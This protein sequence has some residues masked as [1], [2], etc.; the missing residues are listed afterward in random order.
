MLPPPTTRS[1]NVIVIAKANFQPPFDDVAGSSSTCSLYLPLCIGDK[2]SVISKKDDWYFGTY[3]SNPDSIYGIFPVNYVEE[4]DTNMIN[5]CMMHKRESIQDFDFEEE[6]RNLSIEITETLKSWWKHLKLN[7][8]KG[9]D[10]KT[11]NQPKGYEFYEKEMKELM[12]IRKKLLEGNILTEELRELRQ[13][14]AK[15][16]DMNN[17]WLGLGMHIRDE[18]SRILMVDRISG[19]FYYKFYIKLQVNQ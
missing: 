8:A 14:V 12:L 4:F 17:H 1:K 2:L 7:Y 9:V 6:T 15:S 10:N 13:V 11:L 16:I 18:K 3:E 19:M 5:N